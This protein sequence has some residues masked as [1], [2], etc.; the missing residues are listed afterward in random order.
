LCRGYLA[1]TPFIAASSQLGWVRVKRMEIEDGWQNVAR[2]MIA[3]YKDS[4][5]GVVTELLAKRNGRQPPLTYNES[6]FGSRSEIRVAHE[7]EKRNVLFFPL[8][9]AVRAETGENYLDHREPDF[10]VCE[11]GVWGILECFVPRG[12]V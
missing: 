6:E 3:N 10:L 12:P 2:D 9:L 4:N 11:D 7:F 8:P 1:V 5:Q